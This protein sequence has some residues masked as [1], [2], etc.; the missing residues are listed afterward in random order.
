V[1]Q[2]DYLLDMEIFS[3]AL[4]GLI[5]LGIYKKLLPKQEFYFLCN[6]M[7]VKKTNQLHEPADPDNPG[8]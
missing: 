6:A 2:S 4:L 1:W 5:F 3:I 7:T 8:P